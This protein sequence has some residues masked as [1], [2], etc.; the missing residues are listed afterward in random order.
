MHFTR[1]QFAGLAAATAGSLAMPNALRG[2]PGG[3]KL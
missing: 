3:L 2:V 1:R